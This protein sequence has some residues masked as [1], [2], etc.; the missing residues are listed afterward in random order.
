M[1]VGLVTSPSCAEHDT[2]TGHPECAQRLHALLERLESDGLCAELAALE[3]TPA[4]RA[5]LTAVHQATYVD[6]AAATIAGGARYLDSS[7]VNVSRASYAAALASAGGAI[8]A[9][10]R[11]VDGRWSSAF[12]ATRPP[13]HHA[14]ESF[15]MGFCIFNNVVIAARVA[16]SMG[17]ERIAIVDFDVH[18]GNGTQHLTESDPSMLY[19]S[20]HQS[21]HYPG[22]GGASE[23][24]LGEGVGTVVNCPQQPGSGDLEW[25]RDFEGHVLPAVEA[26]SPDLI[27]VSA[28]F[29]AHY[30][31]PLSET[32]VQADAYR[33]MTEGLLEVAGH[34]SGGRI[35]S[36]LEGGYSLK[37]LAESAS[38][39][40]GSLLAGV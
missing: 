38:T 21:P 6:H 10:E 11:V 26:F 24:G 32:R 12:V 22:T 4:S 25:L 13:G 7:D 5:A 1:T 8:D 16:Q 34:C 36:L 3:A 28:G 29:D 27:L 31:D 2:G 40:V 14:E 37:G 19:A 15:A 9:T 35:V 39:H 20:L 30:L 18:H 23:R 33:R 17:L